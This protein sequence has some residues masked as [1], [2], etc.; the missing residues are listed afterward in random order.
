MSRPSE[1]KLVP[2][3][4]SCG[5]KLVASFKC[6]GLLIICLSFG[7]QTSL[8]RSK[9]TGV[10]SRGGKKYVYG[11]ALLFFAQSPDCP[12]EGDESR[13]VATC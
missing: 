9:G 10:S 1:A 13:A 5:R 12:N 3:G 7:F 2:I 8:L 11:S 6:S 4:R